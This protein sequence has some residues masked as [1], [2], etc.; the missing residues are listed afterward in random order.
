M[1]RSGYT[2]LSTCSPRNFEYVRSL[3]VDEVFDYRQPGVG[4]NIRKFTQNKLK[5]AWDTVSKVES[6][7]ICAEALSSDP[8]G[9]RYASFLSNKCPR[10]DI[11]SVGTNMYTVFGEYFRVGNLEYPASQEDFE[12]AKRFTALT[13]K[14]IAAGKLIPHKE[15]I[16][17][18]GLEGVPLGLDDL[19]NNNYNGE[20][21]VYRIADT[22]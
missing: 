5:I 8:A 10:E 1:G 3:G 9:C 7:K 6:A 19:K 4:S 17:K 16:R 15:T 21:L 22:A 11:P 20:K 13:E 14:L 12:W 2:V 18:A